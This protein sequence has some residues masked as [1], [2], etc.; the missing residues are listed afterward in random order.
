MKYIKVKPG[1]NSIKRTKKKKKF[2]TQ[3][4]VVK[5]TFKLGVFYVVRKHVLNF[6]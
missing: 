6:S 1:I 3:P 4:L 2:G 5:D